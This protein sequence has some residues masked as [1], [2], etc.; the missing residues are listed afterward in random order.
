[1]SVTDTP[2]KAK[3]INDFPRMDGSET[4]AAVLCEDQ[5]GLPKSLDLFS[6]VMPVGFVYTQY[7]DTPGAPDL[8]PQFAWQTID[9]LQGAFFRSEGGKAAAFSQSAIALQQEGLPD[10]KGFA[11]TLS[12]HK[13]MVSGALYFPGLSN[14]ALQHGD[15]PDL[16]AGELHLEANR[17]NPIY[18]RSDEVRPLNVTVRLWKRVA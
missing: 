11:Q 2:A 1:M 18:G 4:A 9:G 17:S 16:F 7:P 12:H 10:I 6:A 5:N 3:R 14:A 8:W 13:G 15:A